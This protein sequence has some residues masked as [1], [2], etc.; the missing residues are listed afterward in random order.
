MRLQLALIV[1]LANLASGAQ[2]AQ[3]IAKLDRTRAALGEPVVLTLSLFDSDLRLRA[4][5]TQPTVD[6]SALKKSFDFGTPQTINRIQ[7]GRAIAELRVELLAKRPGRLAIPPLVV[8]N[9]RTSALVID[10]TPPPGGAAPLVFSRA[11]ADKTRGWAGEQIV[12]WLDFYRRV[13]VANVARGNVLDATPTA[14]EL[15]GMRELP[16]AI[17]SETIAGTS[18]EVVRLAWTLFPKEATTHTVYLPDLWVE[19]RDGKRIRLPRR[20]VNIDIRALPAG[21]PRNVIVGVPEV[22]QQPPDKTLEVNS[23]TSWS[24]KVRAPVEMSSL[25]DTLALRGPA[26]ARL[27]MDRALRTV[28]DTPSGSHASADYVLAVTP[29]AP[30]VHM[31]PSI[32][33]PYFDTARGAVGEITLPAITLNAT[34]PPISHTPSAAPRRSHAHAGES[35]PEPAQPLLWVASLA[36][37]GVAAYGVVAKMRRRTRVTRPPARQTSAPY[38]AS[39]HHPLQKKLLRSLAASTLEEGLARWE[40]VH[41]MDETV[42]AAVRQVQRMRYAASDTDGAALRRLV[43][44]AV[45]KIEKPVASALPPRGDP[46]LP[47]NFTRHL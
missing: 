46:W 25:P 41:G 38:V 30:G 37:A 31:L 19:T 24:V 42:R 11:G 32:R 7:A 4:G 1:L 35:S 17:R 9:H 20:A 29:L 15:M 36:L 43:N 13:G 34:A 40:N 26:K 2:A 12:V 10:I 27:F 28:E 18:Y 8:G 47:E 22:T 14:P 5:G 16:H 39:P 45:D 44:A 23:L 6:L 21:V 3:L 33:I